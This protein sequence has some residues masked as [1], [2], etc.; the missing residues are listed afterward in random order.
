MHEQKAFI[1][2]LKLVLSH[3][4]FVLSKRLLWTQNK[5]GQTFGLGLGLIFERSHVYVEHFRYIFSSQFSETSTILTSDHSKKQMPN[6]M[7]KAVH[8]VFLACLKIGSARNFIGKSVLVSFQIQFL[9]TKLIW[10]I[11]T[12]EK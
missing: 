9:Q 6:L 10:L 12:W 11:K 5:S 3:I 4:N 2:I 8:R 7:R 1:L